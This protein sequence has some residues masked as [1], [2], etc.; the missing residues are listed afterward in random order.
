MVDIQA[1]LRRKYDLMEQEAKTRQQQAQSTGM[2]QAAQANEAN[3]RAGLAPRITDAQIDFQRANTQ[4]VGL[5]NQY[6]PRLTEMALTT[7]GINNQLTQSQIGE[8]GARIRNLGAQ[9]G[10]VGR[11]SRQLD[12][13]QR[14]TG[15]FMPDVFPI[16]RSRSSGGGMPST[17]NMGSG[18]GNGAGYGFWGRNGSGTAFD[19]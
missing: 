18:L 11:Q 2:L 13:M 14:Y 12:D 15:V 9:T 19:W 5:Q 3:V 7:S 4:Q 17:S 6:Y 1:A 10:L 8:S 16:L